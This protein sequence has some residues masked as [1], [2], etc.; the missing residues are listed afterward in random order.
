MFNK[1]FIKIF[2]TVVVAFV[3]LG[4]VSY[5]LIPILYTGGGFK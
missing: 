2:W 1:K 4:M 3:I 5:L